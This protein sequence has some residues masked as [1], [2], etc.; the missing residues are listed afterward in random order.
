MKQF[1]VGGGLDVTYGPNLRLGTSYIDLTIIS[2]T[3]KFVR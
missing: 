3:G 2:K 1:D